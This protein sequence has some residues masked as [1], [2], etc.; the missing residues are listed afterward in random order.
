MSALTRPRPALVDTAIAIS[1]G[2]CAG[3]I[4]DGAPALSHAL[5]VARK[6]TDH[7]A[8]ASPD[9]IAAVIL[10]D[11]P[12]F[13]PAGVNLDRTLAETLNP[14]VLRIVRAIQA[15]HEALERSTNPCVEDRDPAVL[16]ASAA[17]K[18]VSIAAI[19]RRGRRSDDPAVFWNHRRAFIDRVPYF[20]AFAVA[21]EPHLPA[22]LARELAAVIASTVEVTTPYRRCTPGPASHGAAVW[23]SAPLR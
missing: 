20:Q 12:Y 22:S 17:D 16:V 6:V 4:I 15:E 21:V 8:S 14:S 13:A 1:R 9:L 19:I 23:D 2:W 7:L 10:H 18:T 3:H 11:A 5:K